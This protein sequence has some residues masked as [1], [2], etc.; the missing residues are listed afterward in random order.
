MFGFSLRKQI[1]ALL[2]RAYQS[3]FESYKAELCTIMER[4]DRQELTEDEFYR[5]MAAAREQYIDDVS[6]MVSGAV[7][8]APP[9]VSARYKLATMS[10]QIAGAPADDDAPYC[11]G[12]EYCFLCYAFTGKPGVPRD[13]IRHNHLF[14][15]YVDRA[16]DELTAEHEAGLL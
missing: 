8:A 16:I 13:A 9:K 11:A 12:T 14:A 3:N 10:P 15:S 4:A 2:E 5:H 6:E 7:Y 1:D